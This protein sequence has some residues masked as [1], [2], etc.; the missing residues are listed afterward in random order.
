MRV[1]S[2]AA[3]AMLWSKCPERDAL[4][5]P[6][7]IEREQHAEAERAET[8]IR[9]GNRRGVDRLKIGARQVD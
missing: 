4:H 8:E 1:L 2:P 3:S 7:L 6:R 5:E 9:V